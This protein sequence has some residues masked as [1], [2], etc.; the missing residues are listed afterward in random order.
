MYR[1][2][3]D[4][5]YEK[6]KE[7]CVGTFREM[8]AA[9]ITT[10]GEF[11]YVHHSLPDRFD[12]DWAVVEA[13]VETGIR[14][15]LLEPLYCRAGFTSSR[16]EEQQ[17]RFAS[18]VG[19]FVAH[20][21]KLDAELKTKGIST[22][23]T[24]VAAHSTRGVPS[25]SI[26]ELWTWARKHNKPM[27]IHLEEQPREIEY[28]LKAEGKTP[29][30]LLQESIDND[31]DQSLLTAVH[32]TYT[33]RSE[34]DCLSKH[35]AHVCIC[36]LTEGFLG[37]GIPEFNSE[38]QL[39]LGTDCNNRIAFV[40]EMRWL[41]YCQ[42]MKHN[43]RSCAGLNAEKLV[44]IAT[45]NGAASLGL[46]ELVG[47]FKKAYAMDFVGFDLSAQRLDVEI[48]TLEDNLADAIVFGCGNAEICMSGVAGQVRYRK[49]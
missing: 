45:E 5:T 8:L 18:D 14:L 47:K 33:P 35:G 37:D 10:V 34:M 13:A 6:L 36:P 29:S 42:Q 3:E 17:R 40:E 41:A 11:H 9:G 25:S 39:T 26:R 20:V 22:V 12:L 27:H 43:K 2:V 1:L 31:E 46:A 23:T 7:Y 49:S 44:R 4:I 24:G 30:Q 19:E 48:F 32:C 28:C 15:V 16:V 38:D 21:E